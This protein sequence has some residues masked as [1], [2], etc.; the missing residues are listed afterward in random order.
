ML[1]R[2]GQQDPKR[3]TLVAIVVDFAWTKPTVAQLHA[4]GAAA[5]GMYISRD[6]SKD[7]TP[8]LVDEYAK[9]GIKTFLFFEDTADAAARGY[10]Q[11]KADAEL[12]QSKTAAL[13]K[14]A[15]A[16]VLAGVDFDIPDYAPS[17]L[18]PVAKLG[19]VAEYFKGWNDVAGVAE[20]GAYGGYW[21][22]SRLAAA[23]LITAAVQTVAWSGGKAD[24]KDIACLQNGQLLDSGNVDV[25]LI[26]EANLL[27]RLAWVPGEA[28]PGAALPLEHPVDAAWVAKGTLP[29][30]ALAGGPL[31]ST[32]S[33]V[34]ATTLKHNGGVFPAEVA[35]YLNTGNLDTSHVPAG[36]VVWYP[37]AAA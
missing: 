10:G 19:P 21:A 26:E 18:D 12:A 17:S 36:T 4:W 27:T 33:A 31:R 28:S 5:V 2:D 25:E 23:K 34:L 11:G 7:A 24:T 15:W 20:T 14:P 30:A 1:Y 16:P 8:A 6:P 32:V 22:I 29:L 35:G 9:A 37:K 13:G 3:R